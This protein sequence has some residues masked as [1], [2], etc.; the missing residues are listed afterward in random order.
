MT[1]SSASPARR[2]DRPGTPAVLAAILAGALTLAGVVGLGWA[3]SADQRTAMSATNVRPY[4]M[5]EGGWAEG[6]TQAWSAQI[7]ANAEVVVAENYLVAVE[8]EGPTDTAATLTGYTVSAS[9]VTRVWTATADLSAGTVGQAPFQ[10]WDSTTLVHGSTLID[11]AT[12]TVSSAPWTAANRPIVLEDRVI[13]CSV[14][15]H[16]DG[17]APGSSAPL[18]TADVING[19]RDLEAVN[20]P[21]IVLHRDG[22]RYT[23]IGL[24]TAIDIDTGEVV[25]FTMPA[26]QNWAVAS[27]ADGW[28]V[29]S[30]DTSNEY[31]HIY[32]YRLAGGE[33]TEDYQGT[34]P[35]KENE[36]PQYGFQPRT[37]AQFKDLWT[38]GD[39]GSVVG[40]SHHPKDSDCLDRV[41]AIDGP[42]IEIPTIAIGG[43]DTVIAQTS[44]S[45]ATWVTMTR[46]H[47]VMTVRLADRPTDNAFAFMYNTSTGEAITFEGTDVADGDQLSMVTESLAVGYDLDTGTLYGYVPA[48]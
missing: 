47:P 6:A 1:S 24:Y 45:C 12:G 33:A 29:T 40:W 38:D 17:W 28:L 35:W 27:A 8:S 43:S 15:D 30:W 42:T 39:L 11:L 34:L 19:H 4:V 9:G 16:C 26:L 13:T 22:A 46:E 36:T 2:P 31:W 21:F 32:S 44:F 37:R 20:Q 41:W 23:L 48:R 3:T 14:S 5:P 25:S 18:W 10:V 7:P